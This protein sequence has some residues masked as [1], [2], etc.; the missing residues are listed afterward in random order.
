MSQLHKILLT[1]LGADIDECMVQSPCDGKAVCI[2]EE[3]S[4][5]CQCLKGYVENG[6]TCTGM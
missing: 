3:G 1:F 4:F 5:M 6:T 2:D